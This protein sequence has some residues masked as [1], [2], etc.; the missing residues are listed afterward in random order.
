[1]NLRDEQLKELKINMSPEKLV[2]EG[3]ING[4]IN[5]HL[6]YRNERI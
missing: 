1:L 6:K 5:G 3:R 4:M 2:D